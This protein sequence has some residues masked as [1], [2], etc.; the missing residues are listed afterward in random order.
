MQHRGRIQNWQEAMSRPP[1][2]WIDYIEEW[3]K[4]KEYGQLKKKER[5]DNMRNPW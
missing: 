3:P 2:I 1:R 4:T 5:A